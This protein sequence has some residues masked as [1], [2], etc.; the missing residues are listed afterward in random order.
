MPKP[1]FSELC[2]H[3]QSYISLQWKLF[4]LSACMCARAHHVT[5]PLPLVYLEE[6]W[7]QVSKKKK[8]K[9]AGKRFLLDLSHS[10][11]FLC[12]AQTLYCWMCSNGLPEQHQHL[13]IDSIFCCGTQAHPV[14]REV[15]VLCWQD[16]LK[17]LIAMN[18]HTTIQNMTWAWLLVPFKAGVPLA[19]SVLGSRV[20]FW[21]EKCL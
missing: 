18:S 19:P 5:P 14:M 16:V 13:L 12:A 8:R 21:S 3:Q 1:P 7:C 10:S 6:L 11:R 15:G 9:E 2:H 17:A 20:T 4:V